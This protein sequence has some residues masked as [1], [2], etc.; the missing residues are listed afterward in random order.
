MVLTLF[1]S[2]VLGAVVGG[3]VWI[4]LRLHAIASAQVAFP[5]MLLGQLETQHRLIL[6]DVH[7]ALAVY[8]SRLQQALATSGPAA[9]DQWA[10]MQEKIDQALAAIREL[11]KAT[12]RRLEE[13]GGRIADRRV[14]PFAPSTTGEAADLP[15]A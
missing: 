14:E 11:S 12:E 13:L 8:A 5:R 10:A 4:G 9:P 15:A 7:T 2:I 1:I 3:L 6:A